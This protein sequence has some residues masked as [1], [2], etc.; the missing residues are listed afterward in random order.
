MVEMIKFEG[1]KSFSLRTQKKLFRQTNKNKG[2]YF[3]LFGNFKFIL[4]AILGFQLAL[5]SQY[6]FPWIAPDYVQMISV[7]FKRAK[8]I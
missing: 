4:L 2:K 1:E 3:F 7:N 6:F 5:T 8:L